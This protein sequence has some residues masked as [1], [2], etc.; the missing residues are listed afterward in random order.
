MSP[1]RILAIALVLL[2]CAACRRAGQ[3]YDG[4]TAP[5]TAAE[6]PATV[7]GHTRQRIVLFAPTG[8]GPLAAIYP[9]ARLD[10]PHALAD[11]VDLLMPGHDGRVGEV[12][13]DSDAK[14]WDEGRVPATA[15]AH[16][17]VLTQVV[18]IDRV[19]GSI[20]IGNRPSRVDALVELRALDVNG[21]AIYRKRAVAQADVPTSPKVVSADGRPESRA[22]WEALDSALSDFRTFL[23]ARNELADQPTALSQQP[24]PAAAAL[25]PV[26]I[27]SDPPKADVMIDG[28]FRGTTPLTLKLP[29]R[30]ITVR[31]ERQGYAPW[32][33]Q[34]LVPSPDMTIQP[35]LLPLAVPAPT[36]APP[37]AGEQPAPA[38]APISAPAPASAPAA[39][40]G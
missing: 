40:G 37:G 23:A 30:E 39:Q 1:A 33:K 10:F 31:I 16:V 5:A 3:T 11:R 2:A 19:E 34:G 28:R 6:E 26:T 12:L 38:P 17:V 32:E 14:R 7:A 24:G 8:I 21:V 29:A 25:V 27:D 35:A 20:G 36:P 22:A 18:S 15:G 9:A 13:P 4:T